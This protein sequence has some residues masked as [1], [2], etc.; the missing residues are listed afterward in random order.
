MKLMCNRYSLVDHLAQ[1]SHWAVLLY[2]DSLLVSETTIQHFPFATDDFMND[3]V[4]AKMKSKNKETAEKS[5][6]NENSAGLAG[7]TETETTE[8]TSRGT[9][10][11]ISFSSEV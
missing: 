10:E 5:K 6:G 7:K 8:I 11:N 3:L 1:R 4:A 2:L 9:V